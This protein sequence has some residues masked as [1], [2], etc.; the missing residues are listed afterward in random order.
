M[1]RKTNGRLK[2]EPFASLK[3]MNDI[4]NDEYTAYLGLSEKAAEISL[5]Y[6][7]R[8]IITPILEHEEVFTSGV[9]V[10]TD[11]VGKE[12]YSFKSRGG[13]RLALRPE[14]TASVMRAYL[15]HGMQT[16]PQPVMLYYDGPFFRHDNPQRGR[17]REFR[18]FGLETIGNGKS[19][20]DAVI[21]K[22]LVTILNEAGLKNLS[23][24]INSLGDKECRDSYRKELASYYR[25]RAKEIC[26]DCRDRLKTNPLRLL[27][28]KNPKCATVKEEAP[29]SVAYL[30]AECK[31]HFKEVMEYL[32]ETGIIYRLNSSLVRGLDYYSRTVFE[33]IDLE[34]TPADGESAPLSIASGGRYDYLAKSLG[35]KKDIPAVGGAIGIDRLFLSSGHTPLSPR[36]VRKPE[37][38]FIQLGLEAKMKSLQVI[39]ILRKA[40]VPIAHSLGKDSLSMQLGIAEKM[41]VPY[42][43]ILGQKEVIDDTVIVR[44]MDNRSQDSIKVAKLAEYLKKLK[45]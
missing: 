37:V 5:Y 20:A 32:D 33:I 45:K 12:M 24:E 23:V 36:I 19:V 17:L 38:F 9:G 11:I 26:G 35:S 28:C 25:K 10:N 8:P 4:W 42:A 39:E 30:C 16:M 15:Q 21:I 34:N 3:G 27:D 43:I 7:F 40:R 14:G 13:D 22:V 29:E 1:K 2:K 6:G 44:N 41:K 31:H 18:Q